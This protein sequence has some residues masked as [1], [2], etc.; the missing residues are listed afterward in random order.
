M[1]S[2]QLAALITTIKEKDREHT[3]RSKEVKELR[4]TN[5]REAEK[6]L[7]YQKANAALKAKLE[8]IEAKY[9]YSS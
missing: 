6:R 1:Q 9:D 8:F 2:E 4:L 5:Q 7:R 3:Q